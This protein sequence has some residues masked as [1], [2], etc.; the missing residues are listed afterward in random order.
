MKDGLRTGRGGSR[1]PFFDFRAERSAR[2]LEEIRSETAA[3][4][5]GRT[6]G[7]VTRSGGR[8]SFALRGAEVIE[9]EST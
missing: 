6:L 4:A 1:A 8:R 7:G 3:C 9:E 5:H 2:Q